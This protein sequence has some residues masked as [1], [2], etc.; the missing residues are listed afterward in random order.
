MYLNINVARSGVVA[1]ASLKYK[2]F[3]AG[4]RDEII[5]SSS[6]CFFVKCEKHKMWKKQK[7]YKHDIK[8]YIDALYLYC[9]CCFLFC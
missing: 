9:D 1:T 4:P 3:G 8:I 2:H 5:W 6:D 7:I